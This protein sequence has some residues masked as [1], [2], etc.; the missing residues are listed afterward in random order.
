[1]QHSLF[2]DSFSDFC[3]SRSSCSTSP[4]A[5]TYDTTMFR[6]TFEHQFTWLNGFLRNVSRFGNC[7]ALRDPCTGRCWTYQSLNAEANRLA[8]AL[9]R[10]GIH[11]MDVVLFALPNS[12][13]FVFCYL[14]AHKLGAIACPVNYR[15]SAG[16]LAWVLSDSR[17]QAVIYDA[18]IAP[19]VEGALRSTT[20][21]PSVLVC[22]EGSQ[23][24]HNDSAKGNANGCVNAN[25]VIDYARYV[26]AQSESNPVPERIPHIYDETLRLYT[27]GTTSRAKGVPVNNINEVLSA[28]DVIMHFPLSAGDRT[29]NLTPWFHRGGIHSGGPCPTLYVGGEV[30]ILREFAPRRCL[31]YTEQYHVSFLI[32]VPAVIS[33]LARAQ[34]HNPVDVSSLRG[35]IAMGAPLEQAVCHAY[36]KLLTPRIFNGYG[37]T[38][39]FWNTFLRPADLPAYAGSV[40]RSCTDDEVRLVALHG[41]GTRADP[42]ETIPRDGKTFG[43]VIIYT[44]TKSTF[45]YYNDPET[46]AQKFHQGWLY[47]GDVGTW[48]ENAFITIVGRKDDM[49]VSAGENIYPAQIEAVLNG[50][51]KV[52]ESAVIGV[53]DKLRGEAVS[54]YVVPSDGSLTVEELRTYCLGNPALS[55][56]KCPR[57]Y[58]L[59][60]E[61]PHTANGKL[62]HYPLR[63][64]SVPV[65]NQIPT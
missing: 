17:P 46:T 20:T 52:A 36:Q 45:C 24:R 3:A 42:E 60:T 4:A 44:P 35:I 31:E 54:A 22:V 65:P 19:I 12:P 48:D 1:M 5:F 32:G 8:H 6:E 40:G 63:S 38:E 64:L 2:S 30:V 57:E 21:R 43:E 11:A 34:A 18:T 50:Y 23:D 53:P 15:Q 62:M 41:T 39:T 13:E 61:L 16:E 51:P 59:V 47:T 37:T 29:M 27:S 33:M 9:R 26:E 28:H 49:I 10:D 25:E 58:H 14:A 56:Y 55:A 7:P